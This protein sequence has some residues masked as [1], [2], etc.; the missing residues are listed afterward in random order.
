AALSSRRQPLIKAERLDLREIK[1]LGG[2]RRGAR[3][4]NA[5][6]W[7][8]S[9]P[10]CCASLCREVKGSRGISMKTCR[11]YTSV[12][13]THLIGATIFPTLATAQA[14]GGQ[15]SVVG[16]LV[17][18]GGNAHGQASVPAAAEGPVKS[19]AGGGGHTLVVKA[20]GTVVA[21]G[22]GGRGQTIVPA[23]AASGV[24]KVAA[25]FSHSVALRDDG[26][27]VIWGNDGQGGIQTIT[28]GPGFRAVAAGYHHTLGLRD[29][30]TVVGWGNNAHG[31][32]VAPLGLANVVGIAAGHNH[33]IAV[34]A[35]GS[36]VAWGNNASGQVSVPSDATNVIAVAAGWNHS[37]ALRRDG[38]VIRWGGLGGAGSAPVPA[39]LEGVAA[40]AANGDGTMALRSNGTVVAWGNAAA[41][42]EG[43]SNVVAIAMGVSH[44]LALV[45]SDFGTCTPHK[46]R[47]VA[48]V[49]NGFVVG[50]VI[51]D[52]GCGYTNAPLVLIQGGGGSGATAQAV[53]SNGRVTEIVIINPGRGYGGVPRVEIA[54]PPF[55]PRLG[56]EV[57]QVKVIQNVVLGRKY[58]LDASHD[59]RAWTE[60]LPPFV[61][62]SESITNEFDA[63]LTGRFFRLRETP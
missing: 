59:G 28:S 14:S 17:A 16:D 40:I 10:M 24:A 47:A 30:G 22:D 52:S 61:A 45:D 54:S 56:I 37:V 1:R 4:A 2:P 31:Q 33:S 62:N 13:L 8:C 39:G 50:A 38:T 58:A 35:D 27:V 60:V 49:V 43:L 46:A 25:G 18:W 3:W 29:D 20:D 23:A 7:D 34:R 63:D 42:P 26:T 53:I 6:E 12:I 19:I 11:V 41:V 5:E 9:K 51:T 36:V 15:G 57:S 44:G 21:W 55:V 48:E 32:A